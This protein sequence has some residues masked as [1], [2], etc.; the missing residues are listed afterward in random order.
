LGVTCSSSR[1]RNSQ[2]T[3]A[4]RWSRKSLHLFLKDA[5]ASLFAVFANPH[6]PA[7]PSLSTSVTVRDS[8]FGQEGAGSATYYGQAI[9]NSLSS[10]ALEN[11][12]LSNQSSEVIA[13]NNGGEYET[14]S[15]CAAGWYGS[16]VLM[17]EVY[18]CELDVCLPCPGKQ[19]LTSC[20][21]GFGGGAN[22]RA[23]WSRTFDILQRV[24]VPGG[25]SGH[26]RVVERRAGVVQQ[27]SRVPM[28]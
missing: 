28:R 22:C 6:H 18:S 20:T 26:A 4:G 23:G 5:P 1:Y 21:G 3:K 27:V 25:R 24:L 10:V 7:C 17:G 11:C 19:T 13:F 15:A 12:W 16:C 2:R 14:T 8:T 9:M